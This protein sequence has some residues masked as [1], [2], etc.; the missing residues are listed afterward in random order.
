VGAWA[1][2]R[3][4]ALKNFYS[5]I[6]HSLIFNY[7]KLC[8]SAGEGT[9]SFAYHLTKWVVSQFESPPQSIIRSIF[10]EKK[11]VLVERM[12]ARSVRARDER[13]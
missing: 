8:I 4:G 6:L 11:S 5:L 9:T 10:Y 3:V 7:Y 2:G 1:R 13:L 12:C